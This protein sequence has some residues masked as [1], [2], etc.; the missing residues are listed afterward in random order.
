LTDE[1]WFEFLV[2][3]AVGGPVDE[4]N[5]WLP[6]ATSPMRR[7]AERESVFFRLKNPLRVELVRSL[8]YELVVEE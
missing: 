4:V 1:A 8:R 7:M 2:T 3:R 5:V 6:R